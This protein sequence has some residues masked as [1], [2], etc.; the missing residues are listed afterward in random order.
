LIELPSQYK[1]K[2]EMTEEQLAKRQ[3]RAVKRR[4]QAKEKNEKA[5]VC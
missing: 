5:K 2:G 1:S 3:Q 4:Q